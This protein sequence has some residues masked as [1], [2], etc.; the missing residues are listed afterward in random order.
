MSRTPKE[1]KLW[2]PIQDEHGYE[3]LQ[4]NISQL[5]LSAHGKY[6]VP[7]Q[8]TIYLWDAKVTQPV[9]INRCDICINKMKPIITRPSL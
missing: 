6:H 3:N 8:S 2:A 7:Q 5:N 4:Q 1:G 9:Q